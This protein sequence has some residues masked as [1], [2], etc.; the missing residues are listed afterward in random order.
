MQFRRGFRAA[1]AFLFSKRK[2]I[3]LPAAQAFAFLMLNALPAV[4]GG[5]SLGLNVGVPANPFLGAVAGL[6]STTGPYTLGPALQVRAAQLFAVDVAVLYN[7]FDFGFAASPNHVAVHRLE[8][9]L[10]LRYDFR[11]A[12]VHPFLHA[13]MSFNHIAAVRDSTSCTETAAGK[14]L[15]CIDG[16]I[17][18]ELRH[19]HTRGP[20]LGAG[21]DVGLGAVRLAPELRVIRWVDRNFGTR[22]SALRSNLTEVELLLGIQF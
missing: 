8:F 14:I 9:P 6:A 20:L 17:A 4:A 3:W 16:K 15:Y 7:R 22:D 13:G 21:V 1:E 2:R 11:N 12:N 5:I 18:A 19:R 10:M